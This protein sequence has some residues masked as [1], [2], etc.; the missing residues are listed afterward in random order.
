MSEYPVES[1]GVQLF[2][3]KECCPTATVNCGGDAE[4]WSGDK[5]L[6]LRAPARSNLNERL[7]RL[8]PGTV[9]WRDE[10]G[11]RNFA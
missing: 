4:R 7:N 11:D 8:K 3:P 2:A 9:A 6:K 1:K 5:R 10:N